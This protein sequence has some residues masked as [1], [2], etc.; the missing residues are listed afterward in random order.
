MRISIEVDP[1]ELPVTVLI[2]NPNGKV[3]DVS[4]PPITP[5][6]LAARNI[7]PLQEKDAED[8]EKEENPLLSIVRS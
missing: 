1:S 2:Q 6:P 7:I 8:K 4:P 3:F 5:A